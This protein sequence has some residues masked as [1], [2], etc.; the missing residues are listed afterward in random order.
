MLVHFLA[1]ENHTNA[2]SHLPHI[3]STFI[4]IPLAIAAEAHLHYSSFSSLPKLRYNF[5]D[6][7][8]EEEEEADSEH[9]AST[10]LQIPKI[11]F[12]NNL[13]TSKP[14]CPHPILP[15]RHKLALILG[16]YKLLL[17]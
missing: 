1:I 3:V 17:I 15:V 7:E 6:E 4:S 2:C 11:G 5:S 10:K 9:T 12:N 14:P 8:E 16:T 13:Q